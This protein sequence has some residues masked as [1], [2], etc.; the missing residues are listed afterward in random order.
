MAIVVELSRILRKDVHKFGPLRIDVGSA[1]VRRNGKPV[2]LTKLEFRLLRHFIERAGS[3]VSRDELLQSVWGYES[4]AFTRT[5]DI[6]V[7]SL[8]QKL[9][10]DA[11]HPELIVTVPGVGYE[12]I[13]LGAPEH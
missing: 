5:V 12:F 8:R 2:Y 6:H 3:A 4:G 10:Q 13:A 7:H 11:K 1:Q 9:E